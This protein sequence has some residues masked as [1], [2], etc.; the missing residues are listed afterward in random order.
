MTRDDQARI[1]REQRAGHDLLRRLDTGALRAMTF[2]D[3]VDAFD[4]VMGLE[5]YLPHRASRDDD[6][7]VAQTWKRVRARYVATHP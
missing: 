3:R 1:V 4:R 2:S 5:P 7:E 6:D